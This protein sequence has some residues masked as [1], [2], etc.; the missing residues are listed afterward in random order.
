M[1]NWLLYGA[2]GYTGRLLAEEAI[3]RGHKPILAGRDAQKTAVLAQQLNLDHI[4]LDL[5][6]SE[7]LHQVVAGVDLVLH[8]AGPFIHTSEPMVQACLAGQTHYLDITGEIPVFEN[9]LSYDAHAREQ[10]IALVS[11]VGFDIVPTDCLGSYVAAQLPGATHLEMAFTGLARASSGTAKTML[12]MMADMPQAG[13]VRRNGRLEPIPFGTGQKEV[14]F[15]NGRTRA[16]VPI[17]WGDLAT[18]QLSTGIPNVTAY[19]AISLPPGTRVLSP[20]FQRLMK[21]GLMRR[22]SGKLVDW[23]ISGPDEEM[24]QTARSYLWACATDEAGHKREAWLET[25][26]A[27][28]LTAVS[29]ILAVEKTLTHHPVGALTPSLAFGADFVLEIEATRRIDAL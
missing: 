21:V 17:P 9:T 3:K 18:A 15:S 10:G 19:M 1:N 27:Y 14:L 16:V 5:N 28:R 7:K 26:E 23:V 20:L 13:L 4:A 25:L 29:G 22:A 2:Y 6:D 11:G 24:R 12:A 8:A